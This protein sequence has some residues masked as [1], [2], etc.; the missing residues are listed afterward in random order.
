MLSLGSQ[1]EFRKNSPFK[2]LGFPMEAI[3]IRL[4]LSNLFIFII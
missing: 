1:K 4:V 3:Q 2:P